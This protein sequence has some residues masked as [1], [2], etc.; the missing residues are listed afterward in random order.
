MRTSSSSIGK[1]RFDRPARFTNEAVATN[2]VLSIDSKI[3]HGRTESITITGI[4][5]TEYKSIRH[6]SQLKTLRPR[7]SI[8]F[9][10]ACF[11]L[12]LPVDD[13]F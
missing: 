7:Y 4:R 10:G 11:V 6:N 1:K 13:Q 3:E 12:Y 5:I 9:R 2:P 8:A